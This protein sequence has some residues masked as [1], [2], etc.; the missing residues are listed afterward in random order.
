LATVSQKIAKLIKFT[1]EKHYFPNVLGFFKSNFLGKKSLVE[2]HVIK[3]L[4]VA[5]GSKYFFVI[6]VSFRAPIFS[7]FENKIN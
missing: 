6:T 4:K 2:W 1:L 5:L 3:T 7:L